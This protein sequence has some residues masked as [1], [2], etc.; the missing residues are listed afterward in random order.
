MISFWSFPWGWVPWLCDEKWSCKQL[1]RLARSTLHCLNVIK[2]VVVWAESSSHFT[3]PMTP[4]LPGSHITYYLLHFSLSSSPLLSSSP[5]LPRTSVSLCHFPNFKVSQFI[6]CHCEVKF[7]CLSLEV[8][9]MWTVIQMISVTQLIHQVEFLF[10]YHVYTLQLT[11][12]NW[13]TKTAVVSL[14]V[15]QRNNPDK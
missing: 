8:P 1:P 2:T 5:V 12:F 3:S 7:N 6:C 10:D 13:M 11:Y 4:H 14:Y 15:L 9:L